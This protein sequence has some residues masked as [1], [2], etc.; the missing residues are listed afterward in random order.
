MKIIHRIYN[1]WTKPQVEI[2]KSFG[3]DIKTGAYSFDIEE[4]EIYDKINKSYLKKWEVERS[5]G[6]LYNDKDIKE[7]ELLVYVSTWVNG[8]PQPEDVM[9]YKKLT[10][11]LYNYCHACGIG[12]VQKEPFRLRRA[13]DWGR[14]KMFELNWIFDE[15]FVKKDLY[16]SVFRGM[17]LD[18]W[19]VLI[20]KKETIIEDTIQLKIPIVE[21]SLLLENQPFE[22]CKKC[23]RK[24]YD[25]QI[26][27]Y[28]PGLKKEV[29]E[30][31]KIFKTSEYF[32]SGGAADRRIL[33]KKE[34]LNRLYELNVKSKVWAVR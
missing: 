9:S 23:G 1:E 24:K 7:S 29:P 2:L 10:Y 25:P 6:T 20:C 14:K 28:F 30:Q 17:G 19:P 22:V 15:V 3:I 18:Y 11:N 4:G 26:M 34:V 5:G 12:S 13:P 16:E 32:G 31:L 8:Y 27:G 21:N 33:I